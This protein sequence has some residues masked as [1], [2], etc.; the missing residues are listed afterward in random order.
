MEKYIDYLVEWLQEKVRETKTKGIIVGVSGGID[1]AVVA[2]LIKKAFPNNSMGLIMPCHSSQ[3]DVDD[4]LIVVDE[5][6]LDYKII[7]LDSTFDALINE[8]I[9]PQINIESNFK[10]AQANTKAR[11]RMTSLYAIAQN[12]GYLVSGTDNACEWYTGYFTKYGDGGADIA[13]LIHLSKTQVY[14]MAHL[15]NV[16]SIIIDKKPS[17]GLIEDVNDE[18]EMQVTYQELESYMNGLEVSKQAKDRIDFLHNASAHKRSIIA[19]P[20]KKVSDM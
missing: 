18:D 3:S 12:Y 17:A 19:S 1:S 5:F 2:A 8:E 9:M 14:E 11:L 10:L 6:N 7:N 16:N 4:A 15:L 20:L 13:P